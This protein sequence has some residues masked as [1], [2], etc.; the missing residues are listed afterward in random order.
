MTKKSA[1]QISR[2]KQRIAFVSRSLLQKPGFILD[3][4]LYQRHESINSCSFEHWILCSY[5]GPIWHILECGAEFYIEIAVKNR[6]KSLWS[7]KSEIQFLSQ[8][9][10]ICFGSISTL[11]KQMVVR[12]LMSWL[13]ITFLF[14]MK[15]ICVVVVPF[16]LYF[17]YRT[18]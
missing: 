15:I 3:L 1:L 13:W 10:Q 2:Q 14:A 8:N 6:C 17:P 5:L 11:C 18:K 7:A 4:F 12:Q 9:L 16:T